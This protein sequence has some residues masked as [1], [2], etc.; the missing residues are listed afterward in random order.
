[1]KKQQFEELLISV[2]QA[3]KIMRGEVREA[4]SFVYSPIDVK[5]IREKTGL[6]QSDFSVL[7]H[8]SP[9]TLQNWEQGRRV[10]NGPALAL[11]RILKKD[12]EYVISVLNKEH[13]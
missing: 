12:P 4:R 7:I 13:L 6:S 9:K 2:K 5:E 11:L 1:M 10:P 8:I 3:G